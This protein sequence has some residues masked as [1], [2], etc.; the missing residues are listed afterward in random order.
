MNSSRRKFLQG[1]LAAP[2][3]A[4]LGD[5]LLTQ[6]LLASPDQ[7]VFAKPDIIRYDSECFTIRGKDTFIYGAVFH[8]TRCPQ[9][10]WRDRLAKLKAAGFNTIECYAFWNYHEP[11]EGQVNLTEYEDYIK[12]VHQMGFYMIARPG[13]YICAE[14]HRGGFPDWVAAMRFPLRTDN[15]ES[16]KTSKHWYDL[17]LPVIRRHQITHGGPIILMQ[18]ENEYDSSVPMPEPGKIAYIEALAKMA[19]AEGIGVPLITCKTKESRDNYL[20]V[21]AK[22]MDT[23]NFYPFWDVVKGVVPKLRKLREQE[24][25]CPL[26]VTELQGGWFSQFG[27]KLSVDQKGIGPEQL[28]TLT[29]TVLEQGVVSFNYY[30]GGGGTNFDWAGKN[31]TTTY[32]YAAPLREP[33]GTWEKYYR[34]RGIGRLLYHYGG[35]LTRAHALK[36]G[37]ESTNPSVSVTERVNDHS[38]VIFVRENAD[39]NQRY[40]MRFRDPASPEHRWISVPRQGKLGLGPREMKMLPVQVPIS[41]GRLRYTTAEV[42]DYGQNADRDFLILYDV[43][44]R[45]AELALEAA[46]KPRTEGD[47]AYQFWDSDHKSVVIG[48]KFEDTRK[49]LLVNGHLEII[50]LPRDRALRT[51][52]AQFPSNAVPES[53]QDEPFAVPLIADTYLLAGSGSRAKR[54]WVDLEFLPG[55][56]ELAMLLPRKPFECLVDGAPAD[57]SYDES[58]RMAS[59]HLTT[60]A[61]PYKEVPLSGGESWVERFNPE[62]GQWKPST[63][64]PLEDEGPDPYGYV[65]YMSQFT[66][67]HEQKMFIDAFTDDGKKVFVNGKCVAEAST[68]GRKVEFEL[69]KYAKPGTNTL[70]IAYESFGALNGRKE[71]GDLKGIRFVGIGSDAQ[72]SARVGSWQI[73]QFPAPMRG[74]KLNREF[75]SPSLRK[76]SF[77]AAGL[78]GE[79]IPAFTWCRSEFVL[80]TVAAA[81]AVPWKLTF[82]A[83]RDALIFLNGKFIGR[84][85]TV[86]PQTEFYLP[87]AYL[88]SAGKKNLLT[89]VLAYTDRPE[90]IRRLEVGP[91]HEF[92]AR[93]TRVE[94]EL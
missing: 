81:W 82:E 90:R 89:F 43:P 60:P 86:G 41:G 14:W 22:I 63:L 4:R 31:M 10:Q 6:T 93:R 65:K 91:Y 38:G 67:G 7:M 37:A 27:G 57:P 32:D 1:A 70:Q 11:V 15:P 87:D 40:T 24:P 19:W 36:G 44:G 53:K 73:Q 56:H 50:L 80:P 88:E 74:R 54:M 47:T 79:L 29:K 23:Y 33:G 84:Y 46:A 2:L 76:A 9:E 64:Q 30:M 5:G 39:A 42:L 58:H 17:V 25:D 34:A 18:I 28:D 59:L 62:S 66:H 92:S 68:T 55:E 12:L 52:V 26:A 72:S 3:M 83:E 61:L 51:W 69:A 78:S 21:M 77:R 35:L 49:L 8:Y 45:V 85:V 75:E 94:F 13:P 16:V 20:P 48:I 71:M